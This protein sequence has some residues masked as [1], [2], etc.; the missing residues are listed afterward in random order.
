MP[1]PEAIAKAD[2]GTKVNAWVR[3]VYILMIISVIGF[4]FVHNL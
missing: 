2:F 1:S 4:M 3:S